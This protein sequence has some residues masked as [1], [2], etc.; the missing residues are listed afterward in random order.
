MTQ[1]C[2]AFVARA[3]S[4]QDVI[5]SR[6]FSSEAVQQ[7]VTRVDAVAVVC[8]SAPVNSQQLHGMRRHFHPPPKLTHAIQD[9]EF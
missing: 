1:T 3:Q 2:R 4:A 9:L 5:V 6:I 8:M 7:H